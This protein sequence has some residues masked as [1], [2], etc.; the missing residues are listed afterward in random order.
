MTYLWPSGTCREPTKKTKRDFLQEFV[1][2]GQ[3]GMDSNQKSA[4][5]DLDYT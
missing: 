1:V 2:T 4:H 5:L 3:R